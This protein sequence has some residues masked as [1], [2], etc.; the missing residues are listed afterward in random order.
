M[1]FLSVIIT[2]DKGILFNANFFI[3][4]QWVVN[5]IQ[6]GLSPIRYMRVIDLIRSH[7]RIDIF[8]GFVGSV[9]NRYHVCLLFFLH[10]YTCVWVSRKLQT[11]YCK[12]YAY[13]VTFFL[14]CTKKYTI[15][16]C[17]PESSMQVF[18]GV[19]S[20][21]ISSHNLTDDCWMKT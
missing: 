4:H 10:N 8:Y 5:V 19:Y 18:A 11:F 3:W 15:L 6:V 16:N 13:L 17:F 1:Y 7:S 20:T 2:C 21:I 12:F 14:F 9:N